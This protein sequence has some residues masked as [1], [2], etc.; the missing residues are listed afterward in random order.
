MLDHGFIYH[1]LAVLKYEKS[2][3]FQYFQIYF[4]LSEYDDLGKTER[5]KCPGHWSPFL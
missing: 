1:R 4:P 2:T 5:R 3:I